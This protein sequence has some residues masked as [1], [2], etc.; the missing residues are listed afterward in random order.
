[1]PFDKIINKLKTSHTKD[2]YSMT[3]REIEKELKKLDDY[4][5]DVIRECI[6][7]EWGPYKVKDL[8]EMFPDSGISEVVKQLSERRLKLNIAKVYAPRKKGRI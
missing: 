8:P 6:A 7:L 1:M 5:G 2:P 4:H 3:Y